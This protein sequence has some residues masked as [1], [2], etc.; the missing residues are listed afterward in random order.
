MSGHSKWHSIKHKKGAAD[1]ARGKLFAVLIR[2][3]EVA[4]RSGGGDQ[5]SNATL[6]TM[7]QKA[8]DN[9]VPM[10]TIQR[11]IKRGTGEEEGVIYEQ[12]SYEGYAPGGVAVIVQALTDNRNRTSAEIKNLFSRNGGSFAEPGAVSWQ[13]ERRGVVNVDKSVDED[14]LMLAA[15]E[16]GA[17]DVQD[18]GD[19]WQV[20]TPPTD[21][22]VV[23]IAIEGAGYKV[24]SADLTM[25]P[26][27]SVELTQE[28]QAKTVLRL[29]DALEEH[30]DVEAVYAN[31]DIPDSVLEAVTA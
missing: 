10:D 1:K 25:I 12:V 24:N 4:A 2:Q 26:T 30:D 28:S 9:S 8:R 13:F 21:L 15:A 6:R 17:D 29:V 20:T 27:T 11:A 5:E 31:F 18:G 22:H 7:V 19:A 23:R 14:E 3:I 16:A